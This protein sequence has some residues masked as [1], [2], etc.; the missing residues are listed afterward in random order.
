MKKISNYSTP[1]NLIVRMMVGLV[2]LS[3]GIQKLLFPAADG[4]GRFAKIGIPYPHILGPFVGV[5]EMVCGIFVIIGLF[6]RYSAIPL[7]IVILT[8]IYTTKLPILEKQ[9]LW[10]AAHESRTDFCMVMGLLFLL[11]YGG[12]KFALDG[13]LV[14]R[15]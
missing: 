13:R 3:E 7:L 9:G 5:T 15:R 14:R 10:A 4:A 12:G 1:G 6:T 2:F 8:A 11:I